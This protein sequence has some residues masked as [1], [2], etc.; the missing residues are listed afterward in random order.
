MTEVLCFGDWEVI[1]GPYP[2][3]TTLHI[4]VANMSLYLHEVTVF[5]H[6]T[7]RH[8]FFIKVKYILTLH[9]EVM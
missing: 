9:K 1:F 2:R 8:T 6:F 4:H 3:V 5:Q 7:A